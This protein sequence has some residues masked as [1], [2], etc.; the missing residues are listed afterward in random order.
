MSQNITL[1]MKNV[2]LSITFYECE[3][4]FLFFCGLFFVTLC[5]SQNV[6]VCITSKGRI[7]VSDLLFVDCNWAYA[8]W[9]YYKNWTY[10]A[11][12]QNIHLTKKTAYLT[13]F[14]ST[15]QV[16]RTEYKVQ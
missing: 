5:V 15:V 9:Q 8:R 2:I 14:H 13:K 4:W 10:T 3:I 16:Q 6:R 12:K 1:K 7:S 11:R